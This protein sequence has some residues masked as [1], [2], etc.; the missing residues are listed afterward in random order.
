MVQQEVRV[1]RRIRVPQVRVIDPEGEQLGI[2]EVG[3][4]LRLAEEAGLDL[5]EVSPK[6]QPP[7]CRI[8]DFGKYKYLQKKKESEA[9]KS[10]TKVLLKEVKLRPKTGEHDVEVKLN[11]VRGFLDEGHRVKL[12]VMFRGR[13]IVHQ[14]IG[15]AHLDHIAK[16]VTAEGKG[17]VESGPSMEGR[18]MT[19]ILVAKR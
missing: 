19:M 5:V 4:A 15:R 9:A 18:N 6:A 8:M 7:V 14:G 16:A 10:A 13:E 12:T 2:L 1:N 3:A 11:H 17:V